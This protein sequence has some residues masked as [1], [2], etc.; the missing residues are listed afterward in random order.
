VLVTLNTPGLASASNVVHY[1]QNGTSKTGSI[2][3]SAFS[4][5]ADTE[6]TL[7]I[8]S[9]VNI[10]TTQRY[11][12]TDPTSFLIQSSGNFTVRYTLQYQVTFSQ[13]GVGTDFMGTVVTVDGTNYTV[14]GLPAIFWWNQSS[15]HIF[16]FQSPLVVR[17][18]AE[19]CVW[20]STTGLSTLQSGSLTVAT[21][22]SVTGNYEHAC[23]LVVRGWDNRVYYRNYNF[24]SGSWDNW[25]V[26]PGATCD[27]PA[28]VVCNNELH[29]VVRGLDWSTLWYGYVNLTDGTF[30][31]WTM[32]DGSTP[33][34]PSL[35]SNGTILCLAV[36]GWDNATYYRYNIGGSWGSWSVIPGGATV[37]SPAAV[38]LGNNLYIVVRG[39]DGT[40]IWQTIIRT[41]D[42]T[43]VKGWTRISGT[44]PSKPVLAV[45]FGSNKLY[46]G[47]R[48]SDD[49]IYYRSYDVLTDSWDPLWSKL[50]GSTIDGP[51][52]AV[53]GDWLQVTV[54]G[55]DGSTIWHGHIDLTSGI[56]SGWTPVTGS[57]PSAPTVTD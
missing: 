56:F 22:G 41:T 6:T 37:D 13:T 2:V 24:S 49:G 36:R 51:G 32:L 45:A 33:S 23:Y 17:T 14:E 11:I 42:G 34:A 16:A 46:L 52:A 27:S 10:S 43:V 53:A 19:Q 57:T 47:I 55:S 26:L 15:T 44:T 9:P 8:D 21:S 7:A 18:T 50:P 31:G 39:M 4:D 20:M 28:A 12:T 5:Y 25:N 29:I 40:S 35:T 38:M 1:T 48:G 30:S 3:V 54:R